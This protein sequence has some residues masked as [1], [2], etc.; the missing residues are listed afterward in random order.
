MAAAGIT[1]VVVA[2]LAVISSVIFVDATKHVV[3]VKAEAAPMA[4]PLIRRVPRAEAALRSGGKSGDTV[5]VTVNH[6]AAVAGGAITLMAPLLGSRETRADPVDI[7]CLSG[8]LLPSGS[9]PSE[10]ARG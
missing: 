6:R 9:C 2:L 7:A 4:S 10:Q 3:A 8:T 5:V 1:V